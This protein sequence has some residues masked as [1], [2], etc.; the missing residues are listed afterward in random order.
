MNE[1][2]VAVTAHIGY[3]QDKTNPNPLCMEEFMKP[4]RY[5]RS[6]LQLMASGPKR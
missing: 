3:I 6:Y 4:H 2:T 5:V 1:V